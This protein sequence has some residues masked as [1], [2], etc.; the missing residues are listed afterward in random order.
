MHN[1]LSNGS[2]QE[3]EEVKKTKQISDFNLRKI[4]HFKIN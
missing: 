1:E 2:K 3:I 4:P